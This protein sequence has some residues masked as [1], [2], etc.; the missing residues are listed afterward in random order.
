MERVYPYRHRWFYAVG[1]AATRGWKGRGMD[2]LESAENDLMS[3]DEAIEN[4]R[5]ELAQ[6]LAQAA[7]AQAM[8]AI[9]EEL[10]KLNT[11]LHDVYDPDNQAWR[12]LPLR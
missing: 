3:L 8:I 2:R 10:R 5:Y 4:N 7:Q 6:A 1:I 11:Q 12:S 9:A